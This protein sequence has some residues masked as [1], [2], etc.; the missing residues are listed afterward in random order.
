VAVV[1]GAVW[2]LGLVNTAELLHLCAKVLLRANSGAQGGDE[3]WAGAGSAADG[4]DD[5]AAGGSVTLCVWRGIHRLGRSI[6]AE[7]VSE[8][9][10]WRSYTH[11]SLTG[12][13][14]AGWG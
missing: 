2:Q 13:R 14:A 3:S 9:A 7:R 1:C 10:F 6:A 8:G 12:I 5:G 11:L 4:G